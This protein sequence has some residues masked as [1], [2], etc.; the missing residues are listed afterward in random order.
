MYLAIIK[1]IKVNFLSVIIISLTMLLGKFTY[2][3]GVKECN[4]NCEIQVEFV[5]TYIESTC[6]V[7]V[8]GGSKDGKVKLPKVSTSALQ[9]DGD[10]AG[11][12]RFS[13]ALKDCPADS[14][15]KLLLKGNGSNVDTRTGNLKNEPNNGF[16]KNVQLRIYK[17]DDKQMFIDRES[18]RQSYYI[19]SVNAD[20]I[21][22]YNV[23][24]FADG[25]GAVTAGN[26]RAKAIIDFDYN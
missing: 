3:V 10:E 6:T 25:N 21:H 13:I 12:T 18:D 26:V 14:T 20:V 22:Y 15:I 11:R 2:A 1:V 5:G 23:S 8:D 9:R 19:P 17:P 7:S 24:Y 16:A 4:N